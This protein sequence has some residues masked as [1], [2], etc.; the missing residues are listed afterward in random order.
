MPL[1]GD[2]APKLLIAA[3]SVQAQAFLSPDGRWI[4]YT[5]GE[6]G[7]AEIYVQP[8]PPVSGVKHQITMTGGFSPVWSPDG[9]QIFYI[10]RDRQLNSVDVRT[11]PTFAVANPTKLPVAPIPRPGENVRP[12]DITPDGKQFLIVTSDAEPS[13]KPAPPQFRI[14]LNWFTELQQ[15]VPVK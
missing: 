3:A 12:Y 9:K 14:T 11:Q 4:D 6:F 10:S 5:S 2:H 8:F 7:S 15:R 13:E 1:I